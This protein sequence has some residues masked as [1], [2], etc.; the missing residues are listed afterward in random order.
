M[1]G[2]SREG[3]FIL[4]LTRSPVALSP[5]YPVPRIASLI[6]GWL[7]GPVGMFLSV[8]LTMAVKFAADASDQTR[9]LAILLSPAP[10]ES[11]PASPADAKEKSTRMQG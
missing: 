1:D 10:A 11:A 5:R 3:A 4:P 7:L 8:P 6:W 9:W 2:K